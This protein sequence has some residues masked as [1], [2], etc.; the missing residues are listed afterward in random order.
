MNKTAMAWALGFGVTV[1]GCGEASSAVRGAAT[2]VE[3]VAPAAP[4]LGGDAR[5]LRFVFVP[6]TGDATA[7]EASDAIR[8]ALLAAGFA[9]VPEDAAPGD[10]RLEVAVKR[11]PIPDTWDETY[12]QVSLAVR[13]GD[14]VVEWLVAPIGDPKSVRLAG[15]LVSRLVSS[16]AISSLADA[17]RRDLDAHRSMVVAGP[18]PVVPVDHRTLDDAAWSPAAARQCR[19]GRASAACEKVQAYVASFP[20]GAHASDAR[21]ILAR[22]RPPFGGGGSR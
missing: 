15:G 12:L 13:R 5:E 9:L 16:P 1:M 18:N 2:P 17:R 3:V 14:D 22:A 20:D 7:R 21:A 10:A 4:K 8:D 11:S 6:A 19:N